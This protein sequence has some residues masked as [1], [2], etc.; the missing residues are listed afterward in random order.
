MRAHIVKIIAA[1]KKEIVQS[2]YQRLSQNSAKAFKEAALELKQN[3]PSYFEEAPIKKI[4]IVG[5]EQGFTLYTPKSE[6][7]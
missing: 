3:V 5:V 7:P 1:Q 4:D 2:S 6:Y